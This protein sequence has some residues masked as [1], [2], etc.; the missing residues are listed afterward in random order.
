VWS[1]VQNACPCRPGPLARPSIRVNKALTPLPVEIAPI[2]GILPRRGITPVP[3]VPRCIL[4]AVWPGRLRIVEA[5]LDRGQ[6]SGITDCGSG[7]LKPGSP[8]FV[9]A[10]CGGCSASTRSGPCPMTVATPIFSPSR[11][12]DPSLRGAPLAR[13]DDQQALRRGDAG[14]SPTLRA[15]SRSS[16]NRPGPPGLGYDGRMREVMMG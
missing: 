16:T 1:S 10:S 14:P 8:A 11:G 3:F 4:A 6:S 7:V 5:R 9:P 15:S 2:W 12:G 13:V